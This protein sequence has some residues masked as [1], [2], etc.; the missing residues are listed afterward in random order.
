MPP[1]P[2]NSPFPLT[3]L[4]TLFRWN[5]PTPE[6]PQAS[7]TPY[8]QTHWTSATPSTPSTPQTPPTTARTQK[9]KYL[10]DLSQV[11][12]WQSKN[13]DRL[14]IRKDV[15][16]LTFAEKQR[17]RTA[18]DIAMK[19]TFKWENFQDIASF[20]GHADNLDCDNPNTLIPCSRRPCP[21]KRQPCCPHRN[22]DFLTWHRL[23][24]VQL[25]ELMEPWL[26]GTN[27][28]LPYWDWTKD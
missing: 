16:T 11:P 22:D 7:P 23:Y 13:C 28:G 10:D 5:P 2:T 20:H 8:T 26:A 14:R 21:G 15:T 19:K 17:L 18:L 6:T 3:H 25:E 1:A 27:L 9:P 4:N 12:Y 24:M